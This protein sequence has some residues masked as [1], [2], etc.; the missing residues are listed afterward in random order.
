MHNGPIVTGFRVLHRCDMPGCVNPDHLRLGTDIDNVADKV[1][2]NRQAHGRMSP[3][4]K[5]TEVEVRHIRALKGQM[6][7]RALAS[8][9]RVSKPV[10]MNIHHGKNWRHVP[11]R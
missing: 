9:F 2:R 7:Q 5:L 10:I 11:D 3:S 4:A 1:R 6:T 8:M